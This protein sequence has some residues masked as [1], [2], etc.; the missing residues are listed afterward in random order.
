MKQEETYNTSPLDTE[1]QT[2]NIRMAKKRKLFSFINRKRNNMAVSQVKQKILAEFEPVIKRSEKA[3]QPVKKWMVTNPIAT[4]IMMVIII[5][6]NATLGILFSDNRQ[7]D[8]NNYAG[9]IKK[10]TT[11]F[12][13]DSLISKAPPNPLLLF[14]AIADLQSIEQIRDSLDLLLLKKHLT[15]EDS[16]AFIELSERLQK[17][18]VR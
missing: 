6:L 17:I 10:I 3:V 2:T 8:N 12:T 18:K 5:L 11:D 15:A 16:L 13:N 9:I 4:F 1:T 7:Q 14:D